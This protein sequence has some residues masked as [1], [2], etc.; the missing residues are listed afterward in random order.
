MHDVLTFAPCKAYIIKNIINIIIYLFISLENYFS[1]RTTNVQG[2]RE[3][4]RH[5]AGREK[6]EGLLGAPEDPEG[7]INSYSSKLIR[8]TQREY[9]SKPLKHSVRIS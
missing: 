1:F 4:R 5:A 6:N 3:K 2:K 9:S 7:E 8:S